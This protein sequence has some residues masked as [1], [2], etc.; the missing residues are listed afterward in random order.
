M[1]SHNR[2]I[3]AVCL[4]SGDTLVDEGTEIKDANAV[5]QTADLIP[6]A[7][8]MVRDLKQRGYPLALVA[9]GPAGTFHNVLG[10]YSLFDL[11]DTHAIS[12]EV[13]VDKPDARMFRRA[14]DGLGIA[15][16]DYGRVVMVGNHLGRDIK[17]ANA[18][19]LI[20]VWLDWSPRRH[21]IP[22]DDTEVPQYTIKTPAELIALLEQIE[23]GSGP[24]L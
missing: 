10:H 4:D 14:L 6:G 7:A 3:L 19:G 20:S 9:D 8:Q 13:G 1:V 5:V 11:F 21:K 15:E 17:G 2:R 16:A 18:L 24:N 23:T 12:G 22:V